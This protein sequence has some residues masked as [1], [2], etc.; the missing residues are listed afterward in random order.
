MSV[1]KVVSE[2]GVYRADYAKWVITRHC[3]VLVR[4][5]APL[6]SLV[7]H[8]NIIEQIVWGVTVSYR[9]AK[10]NRCYDMKCYFL[11]GQAKHERFNSIHS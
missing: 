5:A 10:S 6:V 4:A 9:G 8:V 1:A 2:T 11:F 3:R 7:E